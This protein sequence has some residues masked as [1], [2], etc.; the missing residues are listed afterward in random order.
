MAK[1][2]KKGDPIECVFCGERNV[3]F[4]N[5]IDRRKASSEID[6]I[7]LRCESCGVVF[8]ASDLPSGH[9][10]SLAGLLRKGI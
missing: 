5:R 4:L 10:L 2:K 3:V 9:R 7:A 6:I 8:R 1:S